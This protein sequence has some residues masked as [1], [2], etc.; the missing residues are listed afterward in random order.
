[1]LFPIVYRKLNLNKDSFM[2]EQ[3]DEVSPLN[4]NIIKTNM[5]H[6]I[7]FIFYISLIIMIILMVFFRY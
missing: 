4:F 2:L 6:Y 5:I 7:H 1:M 3:Q